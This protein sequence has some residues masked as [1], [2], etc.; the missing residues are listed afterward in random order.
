MFEPSR[1]NIEHLNR[2]FGE[3]HKITV[4]GFG[5]GSHDQDCT[6]YADTAGSGMA[7]LTKRNLDHFGID[8]DHAESVRIRRFDEYWEAVLDKRMIDL[9]KIDVE[10][11]ELEVLNGIGNAISF[12]NIIQFEFGGCNIDTRSYFR[13]FWH[14]FQQ[15]KFDIF[16]I[17]PFGISAVKKYSEMDECFVTTNFLAR[18]RS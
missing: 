5:L 15:N 10:G 14:F 6:L 13:D 9:V 4:N 16:R 3:N 11:H 1:T 12:I 7:S 18:K 17:T 2:R 8:F